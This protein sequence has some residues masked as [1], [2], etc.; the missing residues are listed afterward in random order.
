MSRL[1]SCVLLWCVVRGVYQ[2]LHIPL[3]PHATLY[4]GASSNCTL[5]EMCW[6]LFAL[7]GGR[8]GGGGHLVMGFKGP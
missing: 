8:G 4:W 3:E 6:C 1:P 5:R 7:H 2:E